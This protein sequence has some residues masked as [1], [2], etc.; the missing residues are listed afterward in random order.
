[1]PEL[2]QSEIA[3]LLGWSNTKT[4]FMLKQAVA[5]LVEALKA[6]HAKQLLDSDPDQIV[7]VSMYDFEINPPSSEDGD[8]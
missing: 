8:E 3:Q 5:E 2:V 1:M 4:H 6:N 7:E